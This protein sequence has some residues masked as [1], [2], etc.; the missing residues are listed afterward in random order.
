MKTITINI[1]IR[2]AVPVE[3]AIIEDRGQAFIVFG[4]NN[5]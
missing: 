5:S 4:E 1:N 2:P 3:H